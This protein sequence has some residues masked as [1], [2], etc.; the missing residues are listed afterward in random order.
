MSRNLTI[1]HLSLHSI[2]APGSVVI[3][4]TMEMSFIRFKLQRHVTFVKVCASRVSARR[5]SALIKEDSCPRVSGIK[6]GP[7]TRQKLRRSPST[8]VDGDD[9]NR[10]I[11]LHY[12]FKSVLARDVSRSGA[13]GA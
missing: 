13:I 7:L 10:K 3:L 6:A 2:G 8:R 12:S 5:G 4:Y 11:N 9:D 1:F